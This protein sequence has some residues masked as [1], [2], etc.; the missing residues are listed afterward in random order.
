MD[1]FYSISL[2]FPYS[3]FN[4]GILFFVLLF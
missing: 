1:Y 3:N 4:S 2:K